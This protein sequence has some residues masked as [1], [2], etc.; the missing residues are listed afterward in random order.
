MALK[1]INHDADVSEAAH[2]AEVKAKNARIDELKTKSRENGTMP[3]A[4]GGNTN[5]VRQGGM[6]AIEEMD[7]WERGNMTRKR[8][9]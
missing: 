2:I 3:P 1:A 8:R 6:S 5:S 4:M 7:V 9:N